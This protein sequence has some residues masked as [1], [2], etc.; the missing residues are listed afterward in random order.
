[1]ISRQLFVTTVLRNETQMWL[2]CFS[3]VEDYK[4]FRKASMAVSCDM[5]AKHLCITVWGNLLNIDSDVSR[6]LGLFPS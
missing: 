4:S 2:L 6:N 1:M 5:F 3:F